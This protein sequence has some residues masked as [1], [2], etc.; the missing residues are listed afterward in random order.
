MTMEQWTEKLSISPANL[1]YYVGRFASD[2]GWKA[3]NGDELARTVLMRKLGFSN[4]W[5]EQLREERVTL[6]EA[7]DGC[8][9]VRRRLPETEKAALR[10]LT[11]RGLSLEDCAAMIRRLGLPTPRQDV[12]FWGRMPAL[13]ELAAVAVLF[14][15]LA[16]ARGVL[17]LP[18][19]ALLLLPLRA[20]VKTAMDLRFW[21]SLQSK[22]LDTETE[23]R[24]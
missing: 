7:V 24:V 22:V 2:D 5:L 18:A 6:A 23:E 1:R 20:W 16:L 15:A 21:R 13:P 10:T 12:M 4:A 19:A 3:G 11:W 14:G 8:A 17:W 9:R